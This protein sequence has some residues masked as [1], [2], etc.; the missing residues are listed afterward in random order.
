MQRKKYMV[1]WRHVDA[2][3]SQSF[4]LIGSFEDALWPN[5]H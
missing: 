4:L 2:N 1:D 5:K 3:G